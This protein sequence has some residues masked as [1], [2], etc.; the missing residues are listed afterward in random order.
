[1]WWYAM[2]QLL[3]LPLLLICCLNPELVYVIGLKNNSLLLALLAILLFAHAW[4]SFSSVEVSHPETCGYTEIPWLII[5]LP[6]RIARKPNNEPP[7]TRS[8]W[9][10]NTTWQLNGWT[11]R[12]FMAL[13]LPHS[14]VTSCCNSLFLVLYS[15]CFLF[16]T[17]NWCYIIPDAAL[18]ETCQD[19][20]SL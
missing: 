6:I 7:P 9:Y 19:H 4:S 13:S 11:L 15:R 5:I 3:Q 16:D 1:M 10:L 14:T 20:G 18:V 12:L 2:V 8:L 17:A